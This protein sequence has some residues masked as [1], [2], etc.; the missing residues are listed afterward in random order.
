ME[1][2]E[3]GGVWARKGGGEARGS[4][5]CESGWVKLTHPPHTPCL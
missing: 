5:V 2:G 1:G 4:N 3:G